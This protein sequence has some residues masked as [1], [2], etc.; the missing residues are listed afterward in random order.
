MIEKCYRHFGKK[1][2]EFSQK[3]KNR[4]P[5]DPIIPLL[6][7]YPKKIKPIYKRDICT[8]MFTTALFIIAK[9]CKQP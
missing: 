9:T 2:I 8:L 5:H 1:G 3:I 4:T 7:I 6:H